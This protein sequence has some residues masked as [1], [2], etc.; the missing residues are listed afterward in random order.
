MARIQKRDENFKYWRQYHNHT[1]CWITSFGMLLS[2]KVNRLLYSFFYGHDS[3]KAS[4]TDT[5]RVQKLIIFFTCFNLIFTSVPILIVDVVGLMY[6]SWGT[7][8]YISFIET[9]VLT[10]MILIL[11]FVELCRLKRL[12]ADSA[13]DYK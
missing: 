4:F 2:F 8:L 10:I 6:L 11:T 9:A 1:Y 5:G 13:P 12:L 7:Q 3:F